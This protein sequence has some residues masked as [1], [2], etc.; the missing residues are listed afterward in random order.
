M[1]ETQENWVTHPKGRNPHLKYHLQLKAKEDVGVRGLGHQ[2]GGRQ[3]TWRWKSK[4]LVDKCLLGQRQWD[5]ERNF[6]KQ[7]L[8][9]FTLSTCLVPTIV[10][11]GDSSLPGTG[12]PS[13]FFR[14][15]GGRSRFFLSLLSLDCFQLKIICM[16]KRLYGV[17]NFAPLQCRGSR[18]ILGT[19]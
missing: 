11:Y 5:T 7:T 4:C 3:L 10:M 19:Q 12:P 13:T 6:N 18:H 15:L 1:G 2:R 17:A 9:G 16:P 8:L 14:Q